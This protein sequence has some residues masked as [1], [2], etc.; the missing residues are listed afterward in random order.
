MGRFRYNRIVRHRDGGLF[1]PLL[2]SGA[3][4]SRQAV[5]DGRKGMSGI[6][7]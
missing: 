2:D 4:Q 3:V 6:S 1:S 7:P 5:A